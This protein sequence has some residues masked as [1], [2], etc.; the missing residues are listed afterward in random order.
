MARLNW[1]PPTITI[2]A[3]FQYNAPYALEEHEL[4]GNHWTDRGL[5]GSEVPK[6][7]ASV[8][9]GNLNEAFKKTAE[10][11]GERFQNECPVK[12]GTL[13]ASFNIEYKPL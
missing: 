7:M 12:T 13:K 10:Y 8:F 6:H 4:N 2:Y 1:T 9:T 5:A 3:E 11:L